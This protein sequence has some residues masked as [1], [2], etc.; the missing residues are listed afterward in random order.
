[1]KNETGSF[2][3]VFC[4]CTTKIGK[5]YLNDLTAALGP[6]DTGF[7]IV[8]L[9]SVRG[10]HSSA[11]PRLNAVPPRRM[12]TEIALQRVAGFR[13]LQGCPQKTDRRTTKSA[14]SPSIGLH[15]VAAESRNS[16]PS[17]FQGLWESGNR[18]GSTDCPSSLKRNILSSRSENLPRPMENR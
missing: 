11:K 8:I 3:R 10:S 15:L 2:G 6:K 17:E 16:A 4:N 18:A 1:M 12:T 13:V 7:W 5:L 14:S 9:I